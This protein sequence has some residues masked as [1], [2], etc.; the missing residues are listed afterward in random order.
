MLLKKRLN[1][2]IISILLAGITI[3]FIPKDLFE[4]YYLEKLSEKNVK[5]NI[6]SYYSDIDNDGKYEEIEYQKEKI[7]QYSNAI[8]YKLNGK[9]L[10]IYNLEANEFF[11]SEHLT[12]ADFDKNN[13]K[14]TTLHDIFFK[15]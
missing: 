7:G 8:K 15:S 3:Y 11:V 10:Q 14:E 9:Y 4:Q 2:I 6:S 12:F 13:I 1:N 5:P